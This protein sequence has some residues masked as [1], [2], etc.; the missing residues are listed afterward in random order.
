MRQQLG[1]LL[2]LLVSLAQPC[3]SEIQVAVY[4]NTAFGS[5]GLLRNATV[6]NIDRFAG[7]GCNQSAVFLGRISA[8]DVGS[9]VVFSAKVDTDATVRV[10]VADFL[11]L[12]CTRA[13][14][15]PAVPTT[16]T[17]TS[18][19]ALPAAIT[20]HGSLI[21]VQYS[22]VCRSNPDDTLATEAA[23]YLSVLWGVQGPAS[24]HVNS[25]TQSSS[26]STPNDNG[27]ETAVLYY[28]AK[29][30]DAP[31]CLTPSCKTTQVASGYTVQSPNEGHSNATCT[32]PACVLMCP[33]SPMCCCPASGADY[34]PLYF[35]WSAT[36]Q[37]NWVRT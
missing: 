22:R 25:S 29:R 34:V 35:S 3:R 36:N 32:A 9:D 27:D 24:L 18:T 14:N 4:N 28:N 1:R 13:Q 15:A 30:G 31:L 21:R 8:P 16:R 26:A 12:E 17:I 19:L 33:G 37:D 5:A 23:G 20:A 7:V 11:V 10:W 6:P 2:V